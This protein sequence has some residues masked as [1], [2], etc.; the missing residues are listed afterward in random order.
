V[1]EIGMEQQEQ[2]R[3]ESVLDY[4]RPPRLEV[5]AHH[6]VVEHRGI[7]VADSPQPW[8]ILETYHAPAYY[9]PR[10]DVRTDLLR[11]SATRTVCEFKGVAS[12][13]DLVLPD[14]TVVR[15]ACW[16]YA[17]PTPAFRAMAHALCFYP[18]RVDRCTVDGEVVVP[19]RSSFYGDWPTSWIEGP[20]KGA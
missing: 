16:W 19:L 4:P 11:P 5:S 14:G 18:Q 12:Y 10:E 20:I 7:V 2:V 1:K 8:H 9:L 17:D 6:V 13:A 15:D 3:R